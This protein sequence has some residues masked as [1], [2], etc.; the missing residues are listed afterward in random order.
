MQVRYPYFQ[1]VIGPSIASSAYNLDIS[2]AVWRSCYEGA[3]TWLN[4]VERGRQYAAGDQ[5]GCI[6][7]WFSGRWYTQPALD[8]ISAVQAY[9]SQR[10]WETPGFIASQG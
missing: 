2:Y 7:R 5:W 10:I 8:Y 4:D 6:G 9:L 3:E 1:D